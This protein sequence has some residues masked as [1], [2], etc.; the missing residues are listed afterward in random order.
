MQRFE[1]SFQKLLKYKSTFIKILASFIL[2]VA[3]QYGINHFLS[4]ARGEAFFNDH[5]IAASIFIIV[6]MSISHVL[7]PLFA[8]PI[9]YASLSIFGIWQTS[10]YT[11]LAG[12]ISG[13]IGFWISRKYGRKIVMDLIGKEAMK[14]VDYFIHHSGTGILIVSRIIGFSLFEVITYAFGLTSMSFRKYYL[15]T[16]LASIIPNLII[17]FAFQ[18]FDFH[19]LTSLILFMVFLGIIQ[20]VYIWILRLRWKSQ[21]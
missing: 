11:Y 9:S 20:G 7:A 17:P 18:R 15:I 13:A 4:T 2:I 3:L 12:L 16:A 14:Q 19:D 8:A 5:F 10:L 21:V 1:D 6:Y